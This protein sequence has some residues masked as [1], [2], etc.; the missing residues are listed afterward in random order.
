MRSSPRIVSA[1]FAAHCAISAPVSG[2]A[3]AGSAALVR[4]QC[5]KADSTV[6]SRAC[7]N[8]QKYFAGAPER[9]LPTTLL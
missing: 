6:L 9:L 2:I 8:V 5:L 4:T 7:A 1:Q 3:A